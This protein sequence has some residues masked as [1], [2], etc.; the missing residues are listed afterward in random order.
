M[1][2]WVQIVAVLTH[3][4]N[5]KLAQQERPRCQCATLGIVPV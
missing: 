3:E 5:V 1:S 4:T 2:A